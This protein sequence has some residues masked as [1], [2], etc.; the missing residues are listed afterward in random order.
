MRLMHLGKESHW[1]WDDTT[2]AIVPGDLLIATSGSGE[3]GH[4]DYVVGRAKEAGATVAVV[5]GMP[6]RRTARAADHVLRVPASVYHGGDDV[7]PSI[8]PMGSLF[9]QSLLIT[10]DMIVM[11]LS[12]RLGRSRRD[13]ENRHRNVE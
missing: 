11:R 8:Q 7:V 10:F 1:I 3:I 4:I 9:E 2:P 5:T 13:L 6:D 12:E